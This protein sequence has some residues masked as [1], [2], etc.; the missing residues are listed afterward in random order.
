MISTAE[1]IRL[2]PHPIP[3]LGE[4]TLSRGCVQTMRRGMI[5]EELVVYHTRT[6]EEAKCL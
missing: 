2:A 6:T 3:T 5:F 1:E 4:D